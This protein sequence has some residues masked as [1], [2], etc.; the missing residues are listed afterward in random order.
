[1]DIEQYPYNSDNDPVLY[2]C[3]HSSDAAALMT[4][5]QLRSAVEVI[6]RVFGHSN[7]GKVSAELVSGVVQA[8]AVNA[9]T[10]RYMQE[11][12]GM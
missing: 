10:H 5:R 12:T 2:D 11:H 1:M 7:Q 9:L 3:L 8:M 4:E 6:Q